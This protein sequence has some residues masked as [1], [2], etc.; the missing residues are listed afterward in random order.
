[1]EQLGL[2][3]PCEAKTWIVLVRAQQLVCQVNKLDL[4]LASFKGYYARKIT[5]LAYDEARPLAY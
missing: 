3:F 5:S 1:M 2:L 4:R